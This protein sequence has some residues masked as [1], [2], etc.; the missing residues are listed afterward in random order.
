MVV[1]TSK[2]IVRRRIPKITTGIT[3]KNPGYTSCFAITGTPFLCPLKKPRILSYFLQISQKI[4]IL[5]AKKNHRFSKPWSPLHQIAKKWWNSFF[6]ILQNPS[7]GPLLYHS[8]S[9]DILYVIQFRSETF[10]WIENICYDR[11][12]FYDEWCLIVPQGIIC[13]AIEAILVVIDTTCFVVFDRNS[14]IVIVFV[15]FS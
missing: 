11:L 7:I 15:I 2:A 8:L 6:S 13:Q 12:A 1:H 5:F 3:L 10:L 9:S 14:T 4:H